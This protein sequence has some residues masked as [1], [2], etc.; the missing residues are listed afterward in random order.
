MRLQATIG[1]QPLLATVT[2]VLGLGWRIALLPAVL[3]A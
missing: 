1:V 2:R 3:F